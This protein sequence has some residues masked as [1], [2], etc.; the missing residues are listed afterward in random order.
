VVIITLLWLQM[1]LY[2]LGGILYLSILYKFNLKL[3]IN[4]LIISSLSL[5]WFLIFKM[6]FKLLNLILITTLQC[7][8][9]FKGISKV[10]SYLI[11]IVVRVNHNLYLF[12]LIH[13]FISFNKIISKFL[14]KIYKNFKRKI[15]FNQTKFYKIYNHNKC[16]I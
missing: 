6:L 2:T 1:D 8:V 14:F 16:L 5:N 4:I 12:K 3:N 11:K 13:I 10:N 9:L 7:L 15:I